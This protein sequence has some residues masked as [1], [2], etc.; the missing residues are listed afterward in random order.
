MCRFT[1]T[2]KF[3]FLFYFIFKLYKIV[4]VLPNI[5]MNPPQVYMCS[6]SWTLLPPN[7]YFSCLFFFGC[8]Y[9][10]VPKPFI[11]MTNFSSLNCPCIFAPKKLHIWVGLPPGLSSLFQKNDIYE[12]IY[13]LDYLLFPWFLLCLIYM[14][15]PLTILYCLDY[16]TFIVFLK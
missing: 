1:I 11:E 10:N 9:P 2:S 7:A 13:S 15:I 3:F 8:G 4:L 5:K 12:Q 14:S 6:P 16:Y